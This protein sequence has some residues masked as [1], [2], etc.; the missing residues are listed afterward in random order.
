MESEVD[1]EIDGYAIFVNGPENITITFV[2]SC[3]SSLL[4]KNVSFSSDTCI[5]IA[6]V[7][8]DGFGVLSNCTNIMIEVATSTG[9]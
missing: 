6:A 4:L 2:S 5:Q 3:F 8:K 7:T 9:E 1:V